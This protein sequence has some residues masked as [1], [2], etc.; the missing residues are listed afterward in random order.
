MARMEGMETAER[1]LAAGETVEVVGVLTALRR[2]RW[3]V[4]A[5]VL[6]GTV[7]GAL[8]GWL[9]PPKYTA[10]AQLVV[11][12]RPEDVLRLPEGGLPGLEVRGNAVPT[13]MRLLLSPALHARVMADLGLFDDPDFNPFAR[14]AEGE[15]PRAPREG[16]AR[17]L[18]F[19]PESWLVSLG[20]AAERRPLREDE[21]ARLAR[22]IALGRFRAGLEVLGD[23]SSVITVAYTDTDPERAARIVN[24]LVELFVDQQLKAKLLST[25]RV[26]SWIEERLAE[27]RAEVERAEAA[28][29]A[30]RRE[31]DLLTPG[32]EGPTLSDQELADLNRELIRSRAELAEKRSRLAL[33]RRLQRGGSDLDSVP[34]VAASPV[35]INLRAQETELLRQEAELA[36]LYGEKHPRMRQ[37]RL[38]KKKLQDKIRLEIARIA[39]AME[40]EVRAVATRV[41]TLEQE[42]AA[43][44]ARTGANR[45]VEVRL[46]ELERQ[47]ETSRQLYENLLERYKELQRRERIVEPDV[48]IVAKATPPASPSSPGPRLFAAV[49]FGA[50]F[51]FATFLALL[52]E[53]FDRTFKT[54]REVEAE[55]GLPVLARVPL[56]RLKR[57]QRPLRHLLDKPLSAYAEAVRSVYT[58][59]RLGSPD[60]PPGVVCITS[61]LPEEGKT[62]L[63]TALALFAARSGKRVLLL[64]LD[65]RHPSIHRELGLQPR[66]G[67]VEYVQGE[68]EIGEV[69]HRDPATG[70]AFVPVKARTPNPTDVLESPELRELLDS[71]RREFDLVVIDTAP[72]GAVTDGKL[73]ALLAERVVFAVRWAHT[74]REAVVEAVRGLRELGIE[75]AG[76][77]FTLV[78]LER[79]AKYGYGDVGRY[80]HK[81]SKYYVE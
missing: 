36:G 76:V 50:S 24:R 53:R 16:L 55:L 20:L 12:P 71:A 42:L 1:W 78:D 11:D 47:A 48:R 5:V 35:I 25:T 29:A 77:V 79:A 3:L 10:E 14:L 26:S 67:L 22:E 30:F 69:I 60:R 15:V 23:N 72:V 59:L 68:A 56:L 51:V 7:A 37:L 75:P 45:E 54:A 41:A 81:A 21:V 66:T 19:V 63:A 43:A 38:E 70:L 49:G 62:T 27:L 58:G 39:A 57:G 46:R 74:E 33:I 52:L 40:N 9:R 34:E 32:G 65:L 64:D 8:F 4:A 44:K 13:Q 2:R 6:L 28:V 17:L 73:A 31:H 61:A 80:Y 18:S